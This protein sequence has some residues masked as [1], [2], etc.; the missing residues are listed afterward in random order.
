[1]KDGEEA[2]RLVA[3]G[4]EEEEE[5]PPD[6]SS[7]LRAEDASRATVAPPLP[8]QEDLKFLHRHRQRRSYLPTRTSARTSCKK[9]T[10]HGEVSGNLA[11]RQ[12]RPL[13]PRSAVAL[14]R[15]CGPHPRSARSA[16]FRRTSRSLPSH[17]CKRDGEAMLKRKGCELNG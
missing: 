7:R 11:R 10:T 13:V 9:N 16:G 8:G 17:G 4:D 14:R 2:G 15:R 3:R 6:E 12:R 1:M 5:P